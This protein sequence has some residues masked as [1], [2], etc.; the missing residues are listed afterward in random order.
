[1]KKFLVLLA[2]FALPSL[3]T[4]FQPRTGLWYKETESGDGFGRV[5]G[6]GVGV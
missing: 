4:A 6:R 3:A 2:L 1:M 5:P